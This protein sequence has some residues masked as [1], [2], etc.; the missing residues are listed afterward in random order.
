MAQHVWGIFWESHLSCVFK[1]FFGIIFLLLFYLR[2][3]KNKQTNKKTKT[4][5]QGGHG[6]LGS[7]LHCIVSL[8][9]THPSP[10]YCHPPQYP[11]PHLCAGYTKAFQGLFVCIHTKCKMTKKKKKDSRFSQFAFFVI[12]IIIIFFF[13]LFLHFKN[14]LSTFDQHKEPLGVLDT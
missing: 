12:V 3:A 6:S 9:N 5:T 14:S 1:N 4:K 8:S 2:K 10:L 13:L 11:T 7:T